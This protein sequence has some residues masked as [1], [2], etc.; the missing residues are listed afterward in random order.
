MQGR[1]SGPRQRPHASSSWVSVRHL[2]SRYPYYHTI[3]HSQASVIGLGTPWGQHLALKMTGLGP[4]LGHG[5]RGGLATCIQGG[6]EAA[7]GWGS[8]VGSCRT[9]LQSSQHKLHQLGLLLGL[10]LEVALAHAQ[11]LEVALPGTKI[12]SLETEDCRPACWW[13]GAGVSICVQATSGRGQ[14]CYDAKLPAASVG[15]ARCVCTSDRNC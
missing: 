5:G 11:G 3:S 2:A 1:L 14:C 7:G 4:S 13:V 10:A 8:F 6:G 12:L 9:L 15:C